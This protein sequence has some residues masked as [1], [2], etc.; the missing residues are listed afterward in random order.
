[1]VVENETHFDIRGFRNWTFVIF[2]WWKWAFLV[3]TSVTLHQLCSIFFVVFIID[4]NILP[5]W[6]AHYIMQYLNYERK[7][8]RNIKNN[9]AYC[10]VIY[11]FL[12]RI[13]ATACSRRT[14]FY[15]FYRLSTRC[16]SNMLTVWLWPWKVLIHICDISSTCMRVFLSFL[17]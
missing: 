8:G 16:V 9:H 17:I 10:F 15:G 1:M 14:I 3:K 11:N 13:I 12:F 5:Q 4:V 6:V 7:Y 2:I